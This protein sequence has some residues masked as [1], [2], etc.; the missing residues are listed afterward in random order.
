MAVVCNGRLDNTGVRV[1]P[2]NPGQN[3]SVS[4]WYF[5]PP[6]KLFG[7]NGNNPWLFAGKNALYR[8]HCGVIYAINN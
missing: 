2:Q 3:L 7:V 1:Q 5:V 6:R 8:N 4:H